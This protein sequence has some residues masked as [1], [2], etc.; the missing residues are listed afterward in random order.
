M[1]MRAKTINKFERGLNPKEAMGIGGVNFGE[2][3]QKEFNEIAKVLLERLKKLKGKTITAEA[4]QY[5]KLNNNMITD[6]Q[7][8]T[9]H[10]KKIAD[11][12]IKMGSKS[13]IDNYLIINWWVMDDEYRYELGNLDQIIHIN[14]S[15]NSKL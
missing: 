10:I 7:K 2:E 15:Q 9:I 5:Y 14:E 3:F 11:P 6:W 12:S 8:H 1:G 13:D 4:R